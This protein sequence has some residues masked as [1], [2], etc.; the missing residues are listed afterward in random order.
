MVNTFFEDRSRWNGPTLDN[1]PYPILSFRVDSG[2]DTDVYAKSNLA[3]VH[4]STSI[5]LG[6]GYVVHIPGEE[7]AIL[8][9]IK[10]VFGPSSPRIAWMVDEESGRGFAGPGD[11]SAGANKLCDLLT[12]YCGGDARRVCG[13]ANG[14]DWS[15]NWASRRPGLKR[16]VAKYSAFAPSGDWYG[17]QYSDGDAQWARMRGFPFVRGADMNVVRR[18][19]PQIIADF[20]LAPVPK[21]P[22][23]KP[24]AVTPIFKETD[25]FLQFA[26]AP[27]PLL[28]EAVFQLLGESLIHVDAASFKAFGSP[29][30]YPVSIHS[31]YWKL[32][33][34]VGTSD[35]RKP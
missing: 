12:A 30:P 6:I 26:D 20:G 16:I 18:D 21:P 9:R 2:F 35:P 25:M 31:E 1:Y 14:G 22:A 13:Y 27:T 4:R 10:A 24:L 23:P 7:A 17:W 5:K 32:P 3:L 33:I 29:K 19:V 11:H 8:A 28:K 34:S 15:S